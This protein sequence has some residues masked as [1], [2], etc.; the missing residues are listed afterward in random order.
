VAGAGGV[1]GCTGLL[2]SDDGGSGGETVL[3]GFEND[4]LSKYSGDTGQPTLS[5]AR[6]TQRNQALEWISETTND[7][8][9]DTQELTVERPATMTYD[10]LHDTGGDAGFL[11]AVQDTPSGCK[12]GSKYV[13]A[14]RQKTGGALRIV[15]YRDGTSERLAEAQYGPPSREWI[16]VE[17]NW[18]DDGTIE[19]TATDADGDTIA[20]VSA[21]DDSYSSGGIGWRSDDNNNVKHYDNLRVE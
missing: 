14:A 18:R 2:D 4:A 3:E 21:R 9:I 19:A 5:D 7:G 20:M 11:F 12:S 8:T 6:V 15:R 17:V 13:V 16:E 10:I 1:A